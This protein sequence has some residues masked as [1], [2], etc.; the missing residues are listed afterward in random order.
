[1]DLPPP[2]NPSSIRRRFDELNGQHRT[3]RKTV[4]STN[5]ELARAEQFLALA[6]MVEEAIEKLSALLFQQLTGAL[7]TSLTYAL[8]EILGQSIQL[9]VQ[10]EFDGRSGVKICFHIERDG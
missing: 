2:T 6:P 5:R 10:Q 7:E 4:E 3:L 8:Q 1:M 9:K